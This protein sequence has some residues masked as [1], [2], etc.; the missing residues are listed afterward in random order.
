MVGFANTCTGILRYKS[1][2][3]DVKHYVICLVILS[4]F[5]DWEGKKIQ[6]MDSKPHWGE[7]TN[8]ERVCVCV[9]LLSC[10]KDSFVGLNLQ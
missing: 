6:R 3:P 10:V 2:S 8:R 4:S 1:S 7:K 9:F 5:M